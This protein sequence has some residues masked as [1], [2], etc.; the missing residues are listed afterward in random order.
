MADTKGEKQPSDTKSMPGTNEDTA[1]A[2]ETTRDQQPP[3]IDERTEKA[4]TTMTD[5]K[6]KER[7]SS[8]DRGQR[9]LPDA[10]FGISVGALFYVP[11][12]LLSGIDLPKLVPT[13]W[14]AGVI[15]AA[16]ALVT[17][18]FASRRSVFLIWT[19][20]LLVI[21]L[22]LAVLSW[23]GIIQPES[24]PTPVTTASVVLTPIVSTIIPEKTSPSTPSTSAPSSPR[25]EPLPTAG[26]AETSVP[27]PM[28]APSVPTSAPATSKPVSPAVASRE[29][30]APQPISPPDGAFLPVSVTVELKWSSVGFL[31]AGDYYLLALQHRTGWNW[32]VTDTTSWTAPDW[33]KDLQPDDGFLWWVAICRGAQLG[34][35]REQQGELVSSQSEKLHFFWSTLTP[36][37]KPDIVTPEE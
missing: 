17:D 32:V 27:T 16:L 8:T 31:E 20:I 10:L 24:Q 34:S 5:T 3:A 21:H 33:L 28:S 29:Y 2:G 11:V 13:I 25:A 22:G 23:K 30:S 7:S 4:T 9:V 15:A 18:L 37:P 26:Q 36:T 35:Y 6:D 12:V 14:I 1:D 19:A